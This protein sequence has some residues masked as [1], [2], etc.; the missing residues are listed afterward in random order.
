MEETDHDHDVDTRDM[1]EP[2]FSVIIPCY[3]EQ[4]AIQETLDA[5]RE[6]LRAA[7]DYELIVVDDGSTD[8]TP[9]I[10]AHIASEDS[11][12]RVLT[13]QRNRGYGAAL[14]TG[15]RAARAQLLAITDADG[16]YP[17]DRLLELLE[18]VENA[19]MVVGARTGDDVTYSRIRAFPKFFVRDYCAFI[20]GEPIPDINCGL[21]AFR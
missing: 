6:A 11:R 20:A 21:R 10:L 16:T 2:K 4:L 12:V 14:K 17:N 7:G 13:H 8:E 3:N 15:I 1:D 19:D 9:V 18:T 5:L